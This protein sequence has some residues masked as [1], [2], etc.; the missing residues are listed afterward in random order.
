MDDLDRA[1]VEAQ[2]QLERSIEAA[3]GVLPSGVSADDC[4]HCGN[5]I[6]SARQLA[7]PG[8]DSCVACARRVELGLD[9]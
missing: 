4:V 7:L 9:V 1:S 5:E 2:R 6:N 3:R 8:V